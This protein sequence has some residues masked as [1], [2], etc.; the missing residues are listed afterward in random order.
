M[1]KYLWQISYTQDGMKGLMNE[2]GTG[3]RTM[4]EKLAQNMGGSVESFYFAFGDYDAYL[5]ADF[6]SNVDVAAIAMNVGAAGAVSVKTTVLLTPEEI[7]EATNKVVEY[8]PPG[9]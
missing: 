7:D 8:R 1:A 3:R 6:P 5:I 9:T 4:V 2:G